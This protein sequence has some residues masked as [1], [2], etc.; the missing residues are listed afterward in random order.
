MLRRQRQEDHELQAGSGLH[1][2]TVSANKT[3]SVKEVSSIPVTTTLLRKRQ[4]NYHKFETSY[5]SKETGLK[6][7]KDSTGVPLVVRSGSHHEDQSSHLSFHVLSWVS[8]TG[9]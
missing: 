6:N 7:P 4:E 2:E 1:S 3:R 8:N 5:G 9:L